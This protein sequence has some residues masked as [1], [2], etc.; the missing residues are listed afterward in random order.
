MLPK[1]LY[2]R[3]TKEDISRGSRGSMESCPVALAVQRQLARPFVSVDFETVTIEEPTTRGGWR[4]R[5]YPVGRRMETWMMRFDTGLPVVPTAFA[6]LA[7]K[8]R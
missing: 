5:V 3:V 4:E 2:L 8:K 7:R 1:Y 6:L